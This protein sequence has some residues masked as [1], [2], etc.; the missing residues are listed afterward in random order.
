MKLLIIRHGDPDYERDSLTPAGFAEAELLADYLRDVRIDHAYVSPLGRAQATAAP[1]LAAKGMG[2][3]T[4]DWLREFVPAERLAAQIPQD[5]WPE[6]LSGIPLCIWD[7]LPEEWTAQDRNY[8]D[9]WH[10]DPVL[11]TVATREAYEEVCASLD[12]LLAA[13]GYVRSGRI[14]EAVAPNHETLAL[15]CHFGLGNV[16]LSHL[17]GISPMVLWHGFCA[18]PSSVTTVVTEER[19]QGKAW[20]RVLEY[21]GVEHLALGHAAPSFA[22]RFCEC[23]ED[24]DRH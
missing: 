12:E 22:A 9:R 24:D 3:T 4:L 1:T 2:A 10:E 6:D 17:L 7:L 11:Q 8:T 15:F 20:F 21:G 18:A 5:Q 23:F 13:H 14:Y 19:S 16:I